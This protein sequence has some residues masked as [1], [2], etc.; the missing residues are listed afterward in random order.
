[1]AGGLFCCQ[2]CG[3]LITGETIRRK[4][5]DG[6]VRE[7]VYYRC[8]NNAPG[9][10][11]PR[12]RWRED[13]LESAIV[14]DLET[15]RL[16][17]PDIADWFRK[18]L[19]AAFSDIN[20]VHRERAKALQK[21][22]TE[23]AAM[24]DRLLN[25]FLADKIDEAT[26]IAKQAALRDEANQ[27]DESLAQLGDLCPTDAEAAVAVF[28]F[29]QRAAEIWRGSK[30]TQKRQIVEIASLNRTLSDVTLVTEKR[31]PFD[32]LANRP[33]VQLSRGDWI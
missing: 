5:R 33:S 29:S 13:D 17:R 32:I 8:A 9:P 7:H 4:L 23:L 20:A 26:F 25:V 21:R 30:I 3:A 6:G 15:M 19:E 2:F 11:H 28:D 14:A 22:K 27:V 10:N 1:M 24:Q 31:K 18:A 16:P 12:V